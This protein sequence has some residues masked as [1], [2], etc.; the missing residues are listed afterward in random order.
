M[1]P[2]VKKIKRQERSLFNPSHVSLFSTD[3][4]EESRTLERTESN[5]KEDFT[6]EQEIALRTVP[7]IPHLQSEVTK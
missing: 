7:T 1:L 4:R 2:H 3:K 5:L 6:E